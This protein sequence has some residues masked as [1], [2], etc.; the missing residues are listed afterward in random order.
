MLQ[1]LAQA[2]YFRLKLTCCGQ[3]VWVSSFYLP[4][5]LGL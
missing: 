2:C 1:N 3:F 5:P 4:V